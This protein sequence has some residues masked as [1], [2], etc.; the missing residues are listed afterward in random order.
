[1][2]TQPLAHAGSKSGV[3]LSLNVRDWRIRT[4]LLWLLLIFSIFPFGM[5]GGLTFQLFRRTVTS[6]ATAGLLNHAINTSYAIDQYLVDKREDILASSQSPEIVNFMKNP[7]DATIRANALKTLKSMSARSDYDSVAVVPPDGKILLSST[8]SDVGTDISFRPYFQ[9]AFKGNVHISDPSVS[10]ITNRPAIFFSAPILDSG[11]NILGVIRSRVN[12]DGIWSLVERDK[13]AEGAGSY[14]MLLDEN[15]IRLANS[16]SQGRRAAMEGSMLLYTAIAPVAPETE[17]QLVTEKRFGNATST[18][19]Q[20]VPI[21]EVANALVTPDAKT[22]ETSS[23]VNSERNFAAV[24]S[25]NQKPWRYVIMSPFSTFFG[26][27]DRWGRVFTIGMALLILIIGVTA[28][29]V[30]REFTNPLNQLA[31]VADR[32]SLGELDAQIDVSRKDEIGELAEAVS[33]MQVSLQAAI[34]R[35]RARRTAG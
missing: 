4:K 17:K 20:I 13:D 21:P 22:F 19:V 3:G 30:A 28:I 9:E 29:F 7:T 12:L 6:Q 10:V 26:E 25:L 34:E 14:G 8:E 23:D 1:M 5:V 35:L 33:R 32:I 18:K 11:G 16:Q 31:Q 15:G 24:S 27:I 2:T